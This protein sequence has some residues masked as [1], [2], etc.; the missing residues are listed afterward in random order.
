[1]KTIEQ[2]QHIMNG[3]AYAAMVILAIMAFI[4]LF[5]LGDA[6]AANIGATPAAAP[7]PAPAADEDVSKL[8][9]DFAAAT[10]M[11]C[12]PTSTT[13]P[14]PIDP[15]ACTCNRFV[16][17][18]LPTLKLNDGDV[19]GVV[20]A[21]ER[22][23]IIKIRAGQSTVKTQFQAACGGLLMSIRDDALSLLGFVKLIK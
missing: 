12:A 15:L 20:S 6:S 19:K 21:A 7:A 23:R 22:L 11:A 4:I 5:A 16:T 2:Q 8:A 10:A 1:M 18:A 3:L 17:D 13:D 14:A 9:E